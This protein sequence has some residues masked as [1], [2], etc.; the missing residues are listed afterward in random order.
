MAAG[1]STAMRKS[2]ARK[3]NMRLVIS[4]HTVF[5][6][7][8]VRAVCVSSGK[9]GHFITTAF[10]AELQGSVKKRH[11][12]IPAKYFIPFSNNLIL[13]YRFETSSCKSLI[14][15]FLP[16]PEADVEDMKTERTT[17]RYILLRGLGQDKYG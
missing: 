7:C 12:N 5:S 16:V 11:L 9:E 8:L 17:S 10:L 4:V 14:V 3:L 13:L 1:S 2:E 6:K 15:R